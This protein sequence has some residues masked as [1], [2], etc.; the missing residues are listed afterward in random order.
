MINDHADD[1]Q[2]HDHHADHHHCDDDHADDDQFHLRQAL[3]KKGLDC[4][5]FSGYPPPGKN[6][7]VLGDFDNTAF[8]IS[9]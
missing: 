1:D 3:E 8:K 5:M 6:E 2:V 7:N 4:L 9:T